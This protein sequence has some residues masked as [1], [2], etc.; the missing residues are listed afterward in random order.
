[1][2]AVM[3]VDCVHLIDENVFGGAILGK[4]ESGNAIQVKAVRVVGPKSLCSRTVRG[5][6]DYPYGPCLS[7]VGHAFAII[8]IQHNENAI[9]S[10]HTP[11]DTSSIHNC[12]EQAWVLKK[13]RRL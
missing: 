7:Q 13:S 11:K 10:R 5:R 3:K 2:D 9:R 6:I 12:R 1:M 8:A 4:L